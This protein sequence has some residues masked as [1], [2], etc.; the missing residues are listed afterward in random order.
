MTAHLT[1]AAADLVETWKHLGHEEC[2]EQVITHLHSWAQWP[3]CEIERA[4][5]EAC[6]A[7][8]AEDLA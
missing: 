8:F 5:D 1:T 7:T 4:A 2:L 3:I 6:V